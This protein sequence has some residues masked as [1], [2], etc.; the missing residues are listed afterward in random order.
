MNEPTT[1]TSG[2]DFNHATIVSLLYLL[3][4]VTGIT[5][6]V[7]IV[8]AHVWQ[9]EH[10]G[11]WQESHLTYLIRTFW[12]GLIV[13]VVLTITMIGIFLLFLP[14]VW[15]G[16]RSVMSL[17]KAQRREPMPDPKTWLF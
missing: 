4:F 6:L 11:D 12:I 13:S 3:S 17:V 15:V 1:T 2:F 10:R 16:V 9:G 8:L 5:G 14:A 7:G